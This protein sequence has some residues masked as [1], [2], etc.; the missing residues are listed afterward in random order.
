[1]LAARYQEQLGPIYVARFYGRDSARGAAASHGCVG[2]LPSQEGTFAPIVH[3][4]HVLPGPVT[5]GGRSPPPVNPLVKREP[6][7]EAGFS[8]RR[9]RAPWRRTTVPRRRAWAGH[10]LL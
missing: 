6:A 2:L 5:A 10:V 8:G 7:E 3:A 1:M 4:R 9:A